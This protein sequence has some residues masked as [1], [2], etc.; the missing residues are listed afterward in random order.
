MNL[1]LPR[2]VTVKASSL[3]RRLRHRDFT[4]SVALPDLLTWFDVIG[5][6]VLSSSD[7]PSRDCTE[8]SSDNEIILRVDDSAPKSCS[9]EFASFSL[10]VNRPRN[11]KATL[12]LKLISNCK[13]TNKKF[14]PCF[15]TMHFL[16]L[17]AFH[18]Q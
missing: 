9:N 15:H 6:T 5:Y 8:C 2:I 18:R 4:P 13:S 17:P 14:R 1:A 12:M 11:K 10:L 7:M 16:L 3:P